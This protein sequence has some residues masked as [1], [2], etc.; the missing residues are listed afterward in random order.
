MIGGITFSRLFYFS[1]SALSL[2]TSAPPTPNTQILPIKVELSREREM[3]GAARAEAAGL[4]R[5]LEQR[6]GR[7]LA[8]AA[9]ARAARSEAD[10]LRALVADLEV[11]WRMRSGEKF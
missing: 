8:D 3:V 5:A 9:A 6:E 10:G 11:K 1:A 4:R 2:L 7:S